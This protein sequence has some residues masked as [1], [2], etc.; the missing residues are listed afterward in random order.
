M[1]LEVL[2]YEPDQSFP[3]QNEPCLDRLDETAF[4]VQPKYSSSHSEQASTV[5]SRQQL[6]SVSEDKRCQTMRSR[7]NLGYDA[8]RGNL[9]GSK[10]DTVSSKPRY[11]DGIQM[12]SLNSSKAGKLSLGFDEK[13]HQEP[14]GPMLEKMREIASQ[15]RISSTAPSLRDRISSKSI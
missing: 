6:T 10:R 8:K 2:S 1:R 9:D 12:D 14:A 7:T 4:T 13:Y 11:L 3:V 5:D 15:P